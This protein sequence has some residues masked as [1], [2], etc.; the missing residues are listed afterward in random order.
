MHTQEIKQIPAGCRLSLAEG[1]FTLS[2]A[3]VPFSQ[4]EYTQDAFGFQILK[5]SISSADH[6]KQFFFRTD[7]L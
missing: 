7:F 2:T 5:L 4:P 3:V 1:S 6:L